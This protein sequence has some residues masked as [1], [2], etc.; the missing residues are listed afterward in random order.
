MLSIFFLGTFS[1]G[2]C[3]LQSREELNSQVFDT[4]KGKILFS[5]SKLDLDRLK[6]AAIKN[7]FDMMDNISAKVILPKTL[8][9]IYK[10]RKY[11][12]DFN[13]DSYTYNYA[14]RVSVDGEKKARWLMEMGPDFFR[15]GLTMDLVLSSDDAEMRRQYSDIE[16]EFVPMLAGLKAGERNIRLDLVPLNKD[17]VGDETPVIA[18]G[19]FT[20]MVTDAQKGKLLAERTT[21]LP[22]ATVENPMVEEEVLNASKDIY[23]YTDPV[24]AFITD[25]NE[26]W[27]Y[28]TDEY[29]NITLRSLVAS[30]VYRSEA[31]DKC[32]VKSG[33]YFQ[34]H[35]GYGNFGPMEFS[36]ETNGYYD[37]QIPC[38][39]AEE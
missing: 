26:D 10:D 4:Y 17:L 32:W 34:R 24:R 9:Q 11:V 12:Y 23:P 21:G 33:L 5:T 22:P 16:N 3:Q 25:V 2:H 29:G 13:N 18:S 8:G 19:T 15:Y 30:V 35:E 28:G 37:Y 1:L 39:K 14:I 6:G 27:T 38:E 36:K 20:V 7:N 31:S